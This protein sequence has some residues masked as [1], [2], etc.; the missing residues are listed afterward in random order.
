LVFFAVMELAGHP[1]F[2][3]TSVMASGPFEDVV[4]LDEL[5]AV[6]AFDLATN[7]P[8][9]ECGALMAVVLRRRWV[10]FCTSTPFLITT[11]TAASPSRSRAVDTGTGPTPR[12]SHNSKTKK[13]S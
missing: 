3:E 4:H 7:A 1:E 13:T 10:T 8:E 12:I 5:G 2:V 9:L 6:T 11:A